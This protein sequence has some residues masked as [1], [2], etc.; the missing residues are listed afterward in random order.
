M[1]INK[2]GTAKE[3]SG[4]THASI[5]DNSSVSIPPTWAPVMTGIPIA[6]NAPDAALAIKQSPAALIGLKPRVT[7]SAALIA[8]GTPNP[9]APSRKALKLNQ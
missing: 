6:P 9:A 4:N 1:K 8:I 7:R 5:C 3:T 2:N